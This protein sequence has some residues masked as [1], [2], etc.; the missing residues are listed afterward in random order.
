M[1]SA[2]SLVDI[3]GS[4]TLYYDNEAELN[5][6]TDQSRSETNLADLESIIFDQ[7]SS[8]ITSLNG[9]SLTSINTTNE[10]LYVSFRIRVDASNYLTNN[11]IAK[12]LLVKEMQVKLN[13]DVAL[14]AIISGLHE[15]PEFSSVSKVILSDFHFDGVVSEHS[16]EGREF[17]TSIEPDASMLGGTLLFYALSAVVFMSAMLLLFAA[18]MRR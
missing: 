8:C 13:S 10:A 5:T 11:T 16:S 1:T 17:T 14:K 18:R 15:K 9:A 4:M 3:F 2:W 6:W 12:E 7:A